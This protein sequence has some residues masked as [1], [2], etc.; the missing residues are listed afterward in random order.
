[1][2]S[3]VRSDVWHFN[4]LGRLYKEKRANKSVSLRG[5]FGEIAALILGRI[6]T[7]LGKTF[8]GGCIINGVESIFKNYVNYE[9][10]CSSYGV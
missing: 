2:R 6:R 4:W 7:Y 3:P 10:F 8:L 1:M 9:F 5:E